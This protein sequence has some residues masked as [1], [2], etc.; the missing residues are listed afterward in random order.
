MELDME[1]VEFRYELISGGK[2][3]AGVFKEP[4]VIEDD[5]LIKV[6]A[7]HKEFK[8]SDTVAAEGI[9]LG[10]NLNFQLLSLTP[11]P[12]EKYGEGGMANLQD[13]IKAGS[14]FLS[15]G[16]LGF[17]KRDRAARFGIRKPAG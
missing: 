13:G 9:Y 15:Q 12:N 17:S 10:N 8:S 11:E 1:G 3:I 6:V 4:L 2:K 7:H 16:W 5:Y 14:S